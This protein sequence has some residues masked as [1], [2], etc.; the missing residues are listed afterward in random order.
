MRAAANVRD[1]KNALRPASRLI[2]EKS[3]V[4]LRYYQDFGQ[5]ACHYESQRATVGHIIVLG[6]VGLIGFIG[7]LG[8]QDW[9]LILCILLLGVF[10]CAFT[11]IYDCH[12]RRCEHRRDQY[13]QKLNELLFAGQSPIESVDQRKTGKLISAL[14]VRYWPLAIALI[15]LGFLI[16]TRNLSMTE[17]HKLT[18]ILE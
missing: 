8:H 1:G 14:V 9:P 16:Y 15:A 4:L 2:S 6:T 13:F 3:E 5:R 12:A 18:I 17:P 11:I 7:Q 10:G